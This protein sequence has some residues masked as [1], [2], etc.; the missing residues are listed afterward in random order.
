MKIVESCPWQAL[1]IN[2]CVAATMQSITERWM[3][4]QMEKIKHLTE[5]NLTSMKK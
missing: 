3:K 4:R 1:L 2:T 5:V